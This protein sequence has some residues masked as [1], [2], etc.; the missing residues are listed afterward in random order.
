MNTLD[1][2]FDSSIIKRWIGRKF[3]KYKCDAFDFTNSVTQIIGLFIGH[4]VFSLT[5]I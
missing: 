1:M 3:I 2:R 4:D 5:N